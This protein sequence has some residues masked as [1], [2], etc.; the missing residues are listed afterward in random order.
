MKKILRFITGAPQ[1]STD[2]SRFFVDAS[3]R[4]KKKYIKEVVRK[5][6]QDQLRFVK[7]NSQ[8]FA[9]KLK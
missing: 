4:E 7:E 3:P 6:N 9:E 2:F 8:V 5:A 1:P